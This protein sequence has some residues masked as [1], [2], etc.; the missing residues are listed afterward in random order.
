MSNKNL[1]NSV[2][3]STPRRN[4][5]NLSHDFKFTGNMGY[6]IPTLALECVPG[7]SFKKL[8]CK[9]LTRFMPLVSP[10]MHRMNLKMEY[11]FVPN[12]LLWDGWED[13]ITPGK[14]DPLPAFPYWKVKPNDAS[15][16]SRMLNYMGIPNPATIPGAFDD[17]RI[18]A[19]PLAAYQM[20]YNDYYRNPQIDPEIDYKLVDGDNGG[21]AELIKHVS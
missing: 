18:S 7:D 8:G 21:N 16:Y 5:F 6:V 15:T 2:K 19:L 17:E 13:F 4:V 12:R 10:V 1:L 20:V 3:I 14:A 11:Y 9:S